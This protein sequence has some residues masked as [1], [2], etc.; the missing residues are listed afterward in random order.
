MSIDSLFGAEYTLI[1]DEAL[2]VYEESNI[3]S[4]AEVRKLIDIGILYLDTDAITLRF[5]RD[6]FGVD[7]SYDGDKVEGTYYE[8]L[9]TMCDLSQLMLIDG[10]TIVWEMSADML[11]K[12]KK[13]IICTL[14]V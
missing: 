8:S 1:I 2:S 3:V 6:K 9:A 14:F 13:V 4:K 12:F 5:D 7:V 10:K 11:R